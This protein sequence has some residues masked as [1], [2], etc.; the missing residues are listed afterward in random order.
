MKFIMIEQT[1]NVFVIVLGLY[2]INFIG[3][4]IFYWTSLYLVDVKWWPKLF[5]NKK[6][7]TPLIKFPFN[8]IQEHNEPVEDDEE[9]KI[10]FKVRYDVYNARLVGFVPFGTFFRTFTPFFVPLFLYEWVFSST[11]RFADYY[12]TIHE[13]DT[14]E[15]IEVLSPSDLVVLCEEDIQKQEVVSKKEMTAHELQQERV[16]ALNEDFKKYSKGYQIN[17]Y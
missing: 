12:E 4:V 14:R 15:E 10:T 1:N 13:F 7:K 11:G 8:Y 3:N 16:K 17:E 2:L 5:I 9:E 6:P